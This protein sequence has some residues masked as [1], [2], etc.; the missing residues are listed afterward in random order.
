[1]NNS[2][3]KRKLQAYCVG[4][5]RTGTRSMAG[6]F[7]TSYKAAHEPHTK[8]LL[9]II[10]AAQKGSISR[11]DFKKY[12][13]YLDNKLQLEFN[14]S[15]FN[16]WLLEV[17]LTEFPNA[18]FILTIRDCYSWLNSSINALFFGRSKIPNEFDDFINTIM[19]QESYRHAKNQPVMYKN[20]SYRLDGLL[21]YWAK[22]NNEILAT[23]PRSRLLVVKTHEINSS[24]R[25]IADFL[26]IHPKTLDLTKSHM[27]KSI[28]NI[29]VL[30]KVDK[31]Y[32][33]SIVN[34]HCK[35]LMDKYFPGF[36]YPFE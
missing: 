5:G 34:L 31:D 10:T 14:S 2:P 13:L 12:V 11:Q 33:S 6:I 27:N 35:D 7:S 8:E 15:F 26:N 24:I 9:A 4:M 30:S 36:V 1:M 18:K 3:M 17:L 22:I 28:K 16:K 19:E 20:G 32:L 25:E 23:V 29:D 21:S